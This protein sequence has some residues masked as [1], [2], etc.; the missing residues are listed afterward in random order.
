MKKRRE[1]EIEIESFLFFF[2]IYKKKNEDIKW[3]HMYYVCLLM[4]GMVHT[5]VEV[6]RVDLEMSRL[7][8]WPW[9]QLMCYTICLLC[10]CNFRWWEEVQDGSEYWLVCHYWTLEVEFNKSLS[11]SIIRLA[12]YGVTTSLIYKQKV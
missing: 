3:L 1:I 7:V 6:R 4:S 10:S 9:L 2:Q 8:E 5:R 12:N 11:S